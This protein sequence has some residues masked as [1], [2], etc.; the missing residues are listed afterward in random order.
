M[1]K[2]VTRVFGTVDLDGEHISME[3]TVSGERLERSL[4]V[5][6]EL[7]DPARLAEAAR[8]LDDLDLLDRRARAFIAKEH[9]GKDPT[10]RA[11]IDDQLAELDKE[12]LTEA[13]GVAPPAI[14][15][16]AFLAKLA[17][18]GVAIHSAAKPRERSPEGDS[19]EL[20]LDYSIGRSFSD[21]LLAI[22]FSTAGEPTGL[23]HDS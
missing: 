13:F 8:L 4:Y 12:T 21:E 20:V 11:F 14:T 2:F 7:R 3:T 9:V 16:A 23:S 19:F 10:V 22:R 6:D 5:D 1:T 17:L 15:H 18:V